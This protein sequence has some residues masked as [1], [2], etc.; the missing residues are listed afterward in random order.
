[1]AIFKFDSEHA[2]DV[3]KLTNAVAITLDEA[4][5]FIDQLLNS[6]DVEACPVENLNIIANILG[7]PI[8]KEDDPDFVR[9]SLRNAI[10]LYKAKG[11]ADSIKVL[12][13][14]LGFYVDVVPLWT[15]DFVESVQV[16]PPYIKATLAKIN[17]G[18]SYNPGYY[19]VTVINPDEQFN[20]SVGGFQFVNKA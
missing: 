2:T 18:N 20:T 14:N 8:D 10:S 7:Y 12:F 5:S 19:D 11:T 13:Y 17:V 3:A 6:F 1:M 4:K 9:R 15:P 16:F